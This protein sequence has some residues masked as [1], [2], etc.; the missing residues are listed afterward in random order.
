MDRKLARTLDHYLTSDP[1]EFGPADIGTDRPT[2]DQDA[3]DAAARNERATDDAARRSRM[4]RRIRESSRK[5]LQALA[6]ALNN[7]LW[8]R[9][10]GNTGNESAWTV[11]A[12]CRIIDLID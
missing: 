4:V 6:I 8:M 1:Y 11:D 5:E 12:A 9:E 10:S 7:I 3:A 2:I